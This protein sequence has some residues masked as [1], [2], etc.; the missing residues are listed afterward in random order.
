V[1][2]DVEARGGGSATSGN[3]GRGPLG[4]KLIIG[5]GISGGGRLQHLII[6][7]QKTK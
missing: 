3:G 7:T 4:G 6:S 1:R 2:G 5:L